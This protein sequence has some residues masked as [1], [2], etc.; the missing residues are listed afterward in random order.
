MGESV[1]VGVDL[2]LVLK[3][4]SPLLRSACLGWMEEAE[5][6]DGFCAVDVGGMV[7]ECGEGFV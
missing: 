7:G 1:V 2:Q 6:A 5:T 3:A 4:M